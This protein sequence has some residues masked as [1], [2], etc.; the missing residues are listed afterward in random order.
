V[1]TTLQWCVIGLAVTVSAIHAVRRLAPGP[2][3]EG[4]RRLALFLMAGARS[5]AVFAALARHVAPPSTRSSGDCGGCN[6]CA[7]AKRT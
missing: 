7:P 3:R 1:S 4:R 5:S 6:S 2:V